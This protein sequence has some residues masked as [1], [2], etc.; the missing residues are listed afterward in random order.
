MRPIA[1]GEV[2]QRLV[3]KCVSRAVRTTALD[4]LT[5]LQ[6]GVGVYAGCEAIVHAVSNIQEDPTIPNDRRWTLLLDFSN[7]FNS[8]DHEWM[9][10]EVRVHIPSM[11]PWIECC[12]G[13]K[14]LLH[15]SD[16]IIHS[17]CGVQ[18]GD[19]LG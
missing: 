1:V 2:I 16:R 12:Y 19:L 9:F 11:A 6:L 10:E 5:P 18:Q 4:I 17:C 14:P 3:S 15:L 8:I 7:A 13:S